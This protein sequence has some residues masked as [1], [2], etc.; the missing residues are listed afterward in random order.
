MKSKEEIEELAREVY[1]SQRGKTLDYSA[2]MSKG[3]IGGYTKCQ[4]DMIEEL[5][6]F[7]KLVLDTFHSEG[8][9][10]SGEERLAR[11]KFDRWFNELRQSGIK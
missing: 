1:Y 6:E 11:A 3:F 10:E 4:E 7:G 5:R 8:K 9:T 2:A